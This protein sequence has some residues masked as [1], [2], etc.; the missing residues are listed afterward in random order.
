MFAV[1]N[2][3]ST[4]TRIY[5][6]LG[7]CSSINV[8]KTFLNCKIISILYGFL[9]VL[10]AFEI[11]RRDLKNNKMFTTISDYQQIFDKCTPHLAVDGTLSHVQTGFDSLHVLNRRFCAIQISARAVWC[12]T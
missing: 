7:K 3:V 5:Y 2:R 1:H 12:E 11:H 6:Q 8:S 9:F 4:W 10:F